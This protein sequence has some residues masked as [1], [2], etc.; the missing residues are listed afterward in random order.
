MSTDIRLK[1]F[2]A[3]SIL[4]SGVERKGKEGT[5]SSSASKRRIRD[6]IWRA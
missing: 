1:D 2:S 3:D 6:L 5:L 4:A